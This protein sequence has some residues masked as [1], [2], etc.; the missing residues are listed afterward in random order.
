MTLS[1][2]KLFRHDLQL[3]IR[4]VRQAQQDVH[5]FVP[6]HLIPQPGVSLEK[7]F[8]GVTYFAEVS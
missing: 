5:E 4:L 1:R 6:L 3:D 7:N 2:A 8:F